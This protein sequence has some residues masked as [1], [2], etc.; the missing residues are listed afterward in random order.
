MS[1]AKVA[2]RKIEG[3]TGKYIAR[4]GTSKAWHNDWINPRAFIYRMFGADQRGISRRGGWI[5][6]AGHVH[7]DVAKAVLRQMGFERS[8]R[9]R[10]G[11]VRHQPHIYLGNSAMRE[12]GLSAGAGVAAHQAFNIH[13]WP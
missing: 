1:Q 12:N 7:F 6:T 5:I 13:R 8:Q 10:G 3:R 4:P 11:H 2:S 9:V